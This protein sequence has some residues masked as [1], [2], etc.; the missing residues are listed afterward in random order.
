MKSVCIGLITYKR[1]RF[2]A[3]A[4]SSLNNQST[5]NFHVV[6]SDDNP[7]SSKKTRLV[8]NKN[9][10][11]IIQKKN[12][13]EIKNLNFVFNKKQSKYFCWLSDDD[14]FYPNYIEACKK[15]LD[16]NSDIVAV[17]PF[18]HSSNETSTPRPLSTKKKLDY[19]PNVKILDRKEFALWCSKNPNKI[20]G[21]YGLIQKKYLHAIGGFK[22]LGNGF[23]PYS[24]TILPLKLS[25]YGKIAILPEKLFFYRTH[26][27]ALSVSNPDL[28]SYLS[29]DKEFIKFLQKYKEV[30]KKLY[31]NITQGF[32]RFFLNNAI[33]VLQREPFHD[34]SKKY[35]L[36]L[37]HFCF[38]YLKNLNLINK[39]YLFVFFFFSFLK[40]AKKSKKYI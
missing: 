34:L 35:I 27:N 17:Y 38:V 18:Y 21:I 36:L 5:K 30:D 23:G 20:I 7:K 6:I 29:A 32:I 12:L 24:D 9:F 37:K 14:Y 13:G 10:E 19:L 33:H 26:A 40:Y 1:P 39:I 3:Q 15:V 8:L 28:D 22:K 4:V 31:D 25:F 2:L 16:Y 11:Y